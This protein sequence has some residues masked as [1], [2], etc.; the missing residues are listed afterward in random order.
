MGPSSCEVTWPVK[1]TALG[2]CAWSS[3]TATAPIVT[4]NHILIRIAVAPGQSYNGIRP[5]RQRV[6]PSSI[7]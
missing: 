3:R 5:I 4:G 1:A 2:V 6:R 7:V